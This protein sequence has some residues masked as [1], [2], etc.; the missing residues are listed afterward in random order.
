M[1]L[2]EIASEAARFRSDHK[3]C[4]TATALILRWVVEHKLPPG[5]A[6]LWNSLYQQAWS[7]EKELRSRGESQRPEQRPAKDGRRRYQRI[8]VY[9]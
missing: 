5:A 4:G 3:R 8:T 6:V 9:H 1:E 7:R 2:S